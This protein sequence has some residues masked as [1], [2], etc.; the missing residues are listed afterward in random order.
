MP[1]LALPYDDS[2]RGM[3][4]G[5]RF[6]VQSIPTLALVDTQGRTITTDARNAVVR[7]PAGE[8]FPWRPPPVTDLA[9]GDAGRINDVPSILCLCEAAD[10]SAQAAALQALTSIATESLESPT[11]EE[12]A[13]F[14]GSGGPIVSQVRQL[15]GLPA[16][17]PPRLLL[18]NIPDQMSYYLGP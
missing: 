1:W 16:D 18:L 14:M 15:C 4:L 6:K 9:Q 10:D 5:Q 7:D 8:G 3:Q 12:L 17:G 2:T 13:F 11:G